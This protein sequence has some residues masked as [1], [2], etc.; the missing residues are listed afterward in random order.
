MKKI[1]RFFLAMSILLFSLLSC[2]QNE[3]L[4]GVSFDKAEFTAQK[5]KWQTALIKNYSFDYSFSD[6]KPEY[7]V[8]NSIVTE[9][10]TTANVVCNEESE[11]YPS[12]VELDDTS[13][14]YLDSI[15]D[16]F[17]TLY[18][19]YERALKSVEA[20]D[21][22]YIEIKC[23]YNENYGYP[24]YISNPGQGG[25]KNIKD[26]NGT[27]VGNRNADFTF[28]MQNFSKTN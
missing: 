3:E 26:K 21:F 7:V 5:K 14:Y 23:T 13:K 24:E 15:E 20:G 6:Y 19:E 11:E 18:A 27:M 1:I 16:I 10:S 4:K 22:D 8:G 17:D 2:T 12:G 28:Y 9:D 25:S